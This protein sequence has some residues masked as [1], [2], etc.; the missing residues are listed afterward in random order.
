[1]QTVPLSLHRRLDELAIA[2][3]APVP[4]PVVRPVDTEVAIE[5]I[6]EDESEADDQATRQFVRFSAPYERV[7]L[8]MNDAVPTLAAALKSRPTTFVKTVSVRPT[9]RMM[10][11]AVPPEALRSPASSPPGATVPFERV[12]FDER[13]DSIASIEEV[14]TAR[15]TSWWWLAISLAAGGAAVAWLASLA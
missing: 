9:V 11:V 4:R 1:M 12:W 2:A 7:E 15:K 8:D 14:P 3:L 13:E 6:W 5:V 10:A